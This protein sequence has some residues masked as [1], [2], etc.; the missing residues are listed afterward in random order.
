MSK[1]RDVHGGKREPTPSLF[2]AVVL[3]VLCMLC[4]TGMH[5]HTHTKCD[6]FGGEKER[7]RRGRMEGINFGKE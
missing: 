4:G 3:C 7:E 1:S 5:M 2:S 6:E